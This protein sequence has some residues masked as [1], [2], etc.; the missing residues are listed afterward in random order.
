MIEIEHTDVSIKETDLN[1]LVIPLASNEMT[2]TA[3][4][5]GRF[6]EKDSDVTPASV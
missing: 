1:R 6:K 2:T 3:K 4:K 5:F